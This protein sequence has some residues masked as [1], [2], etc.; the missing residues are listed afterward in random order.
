M[1]G[2]VDRLKRMRER[3]IVFSDSAVKEVID[4]FQETTDLLESLPDLI[5]TRNKLLAQQIGELVRSV[6][7]IA[8]VYSEGHEERLIQGVCS[9]KSSPSYLGIIESLKGSLST[10]WR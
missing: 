6:L 3:H 2:I 9:P 7:K 1:E 10:P 4:V 5:L 8:E